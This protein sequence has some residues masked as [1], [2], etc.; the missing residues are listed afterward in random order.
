MQAL[1]LALCAD[2]SLGTGP[3]IA[4]LMRDA[5]A[6]HVMHPLDRPVKRLAKARVPDDP[7]W[8]LLFDEP[9][10]EPCFGGSAST[11]RNQFAKMIAAA[12]AAHPGARFWLARTATT[13]G[14]VWLSSTLTLPADIQRLAPDIASCSLFEDV[15]QVYT[16][17]AYEGM[18]A[19]MHGKPVHVFGAPFYAGWGLTQDRCHQP[20]RTARPTLDALFDVMFL[21]F[22]RYL[23]PDTHGPG[24]LTTLLDSIRLQRT[25]AQRFANLRHIAGV[26][27]QWWKRP[28]ATPFLTAG[29]GTVRWTNDP[30]SLRADEHAA[31][32]GARS[33]AGLPEGVR[34][35]RI[36]DGFVHSTGLGSDLH[37]PCSQVVDTSG[38]YFDPARANDLTAVLNHAEFDASE[39]ARAAALRTRIVEHGLTK[40]NLGRRPP[41]W[42][43]TAG[44]RVVLVIGQVADD[45]SIRLGTRTIRTAE[46]LLD[47]VRAARPE[48]FIVYKPHPDVLSGNRKG[49][50]DAT[51][52]ADVVDADADMISLIEKADEVH[53]LSS[54]AGFDALLRGKT[55]FTYGLPFY[56]GWGLTHDALAPAWRERRL[57]LD[58][59]TAGVLLR[60]PIYW[61]WKLSLYTT[62]EAVVSRLAKAAARPLER[63][64]G[65][66]TRPVAKAVRWIRNVLYHLWWRYRQ[67]SENQI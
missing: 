66:R 2:P 55:V 36:E 37:A 27:F 3:H 51:R 41:A 15:E 64:R 34:Q 53:T 52:L 39:L 9:V 43:A 1:D 57:S 16:V 11:R 30:G 25:V 22:S 4:T 19:L 28:F 50:V 48:D 12:R 32:W 6:L 59:L 45:A 10:A 21:R 5:C 13:H 23:D 65:D 8:I 24:S 20:K 40:Y 26:R 49:L 33:A 44:Q 62:P 67:R 61:D 38:L 31:F 42:H 60:Y 7:P 14:R 63:L 29:G 17:S 56:A 58:M 46:A 47:T 35:V 18:L 54:L